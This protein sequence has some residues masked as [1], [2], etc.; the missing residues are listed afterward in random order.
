MTRTLLMLAIAT[1][2]AGC[3]DHW[4]QRD[5]TRERISAEMD[6]AVEERATRAML[7]PLVVEAVLQEQGS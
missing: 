1:A 3:A 7:P 4:A 6:K 5:S 2:A